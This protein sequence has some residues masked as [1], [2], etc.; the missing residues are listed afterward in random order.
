MDSLVELRPS[1]GFYGV[2]LI[3]CG[4]FIKSLIEKMMENNDKL[5]EQN[6]KREDKL[7][8]L[9]EGNTKALTEITL[10]ID[11]CNNVNKE[12][13]ETNKSLVEE[14]REELD[15]IDN[16]IDFLMHDKK[17]ERFV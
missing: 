1:I 13:V 17:E 3:A 10:Q 8:S 14:I 15:S 9:I 7:Q 6:H 12:L 11:K 5:M 4:Y 16:K 2:C